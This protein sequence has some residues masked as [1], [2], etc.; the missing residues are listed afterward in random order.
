MERTDRSITV[1]DGAS[2]R[3]DCEYGEPFAALP[4]SF[5]LI[6][7]TSGSKTMTLLNIFCKFYCTSGGKSLFQRIF[8]FSPTVRLDDQYKPLIKLIEKFCDQNKE[9]LIFENFS[10][11]K[12][13]E[14]IE[15][16]RKIV[17]E[18]RKRKISPPQ[19]A[20]IMDDLGERAD[21]F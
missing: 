3:V 14:I 6:A 4:T 7:P 10:M 18:C 17:A 15:D 11:A 8:L 20:V 13:G 16:Q 19:I 12:L 5:C 21:I 9:P 1:Y 2:E